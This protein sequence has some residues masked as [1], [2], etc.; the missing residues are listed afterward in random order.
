MNEL[1]N[2]AARRQTYMNGVFC[3]GAPIIF[4]QALS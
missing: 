2:I 3:A 4:F 1:G